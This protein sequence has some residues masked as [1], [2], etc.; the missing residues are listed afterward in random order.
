MFDA[1]VEVAVEVS[2]HLSNQ[3]GPG[4]ELVSCLAGQK[5]EFHA[6]SQTCA[7][8]RCFETWMIHSPSEGHALNA[9]PWGG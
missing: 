7:D 2:A 1:I 4:E 9:A 6:R 8:S 3:P 5:P